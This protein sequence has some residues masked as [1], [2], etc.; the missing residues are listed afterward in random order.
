ANLTVYN[1]A[2]QA[3]ATLVNG[4]VS[5]GAQSVVFDASELTSGVYFYTLNVAGQSMTEKM[6]LVK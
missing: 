5:A 3:V 1:M 2:G 4:V 6:V